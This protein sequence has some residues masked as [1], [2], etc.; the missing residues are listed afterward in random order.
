[1]CRGDDTPNV[2]GRKDASPLTPALARAL[3][4]VPPR[5][6]RAFVAI[7]AKADDLGH[8]SMS[9]KQLAEAMSTATDTVSHDTALRC[10]HALDARYGGSGH[11]EH[12]GLRPTDAAYTV[13]PFAGTAPNTTSEKIGYAKLR[14][15]AR[16][17][18][19]AEQRTDAPERAN[20]VRTYAKMRTYAPPIPP[21][22]PKPNTTTNQQG[23][24]RMIRGGGGGMEVGEWQNQ[25]QSAAPQDAGQAGEPPA[26]MHGRTE[27]PAAVPDPH[28]THADHAARMAAL[29]AAGVASAKKR[30][31]YAVRYTVAEIEAAARLARKYSGGGGAVLH[32]LTEGNAAAS[33]KRAAAKNAPKPERIEAA[34]AVLATHAADT[35]NAQQHAERVKRT[36]WKPLTDAMRAAL[37]KDT[38]A[39]AYFINRNRITRAEI[40]ADDG[41]PGRE[42]LEAITT[43]PMIRA[44]VA[45]ELDAIDQGT[46]RVVPAGES[47]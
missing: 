15:D 35:F 39:A 16:P 10:L 17:R 44:A 26:G 12:T 24:R 28:A 20:S 7:A 25:T 4:T 22:I 30:R 31:E 40:D 43:H 38:D 14:T 23:A 3:L 1:M 2:T 29:E 42:K 5:A 36:A 19:D 33:L 32:E 21:L 41:T 11:I 47:T 37:R 8:V 34:A 18:T 27:A 6:L 45:A 9:A 46:P 13:A